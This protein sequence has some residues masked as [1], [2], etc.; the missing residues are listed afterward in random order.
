MGFT[1]TTGEGADTCSRKVNVVPT[2]TGYT[3]AP[4][5]EAHGNRMFSHDAVPTS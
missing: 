2:N 3:Y 5:A 4:A 1:N